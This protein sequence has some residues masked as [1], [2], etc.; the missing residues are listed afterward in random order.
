[1]PWNWGFILQAGILGRGMLILYILEKLFWQPLVP[2]E[3]EGW[4]GEQETN[5]EAIKLAQ[6]KAGA[7][8]KEARNSEDGPAL[9]SS[10]GGRMYRSYTEQ[11]L[12]S[13]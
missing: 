7:D 5:G 1:M 11:G 2:D 9:E 8:P 12:V 6:V 3:L 4:V 13:S 10:L